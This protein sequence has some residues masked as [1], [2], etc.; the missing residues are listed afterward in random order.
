MEHPGVTFVV[1]VEVTLVKELLLT[2]LG[3]LNNEL[4]KLNCD[5]HY[6]EWS[7]KENKLKIKNV[8]ANLNQQ[9]DLSSLK[10]KLNHADRIVRSRFNIAELQM[11]LSDNKKKVTQLYKKKHELK[12]E[13]IKYNSLADMYQIKLY[14]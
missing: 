2:K 3:L 9:K 5:I 7:Q 14:K 10:S 1:D 4:D 12:Q 6:I 13:V 8:Y 11:E